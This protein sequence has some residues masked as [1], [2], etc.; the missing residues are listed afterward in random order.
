MEKYAQEND[1]D[2]TCGLTD[3]QILQNFTLAIKQE[4]ERKLALGAP[5]QRTDPK[6]GEPC[7]VYP[8]DILSGRY[9]DPDLK[10]FLNSIKR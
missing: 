3:E 9:G 7:L 6:T 2:R 10:K 8:D 5:I 4:D 1:P